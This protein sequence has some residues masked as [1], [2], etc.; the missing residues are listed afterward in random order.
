MTLP[1]ALDAMGGDFAPGEIIAGARRAVD[2]LGLS[3]TLVGVPHLMGDPLGLEVV[4]CS[5]VIAMDDDPASSVR[6]KKDASLVRAA[7]LVRDGRASAM[8][9]AGNTGAT[10][11]SALLRMGRLPGVVRPCI[12]TPIPNPGRTPSV[13]VDAG[14]N[15]ECTAEMLVQ[16][17]Q[18]ASTYV[19]VHYGV[20]APTVGL[21]SIG[22]ESSKGTPLVKETHGLLTSIAGLN[23]VGNVEGRDLIPAPVD[24]IVTDGF[25]GNV[26][27][28]T[29]EGALTF[30]FTTV[31]GVV[32][33]NEE[34]RA[35]GRVLLDYLLPVAGELTPENQGGAML[36]GLNGICVISHGSSN[37]TAVMN[38]LR[39]AAEMDSAGVVD[40]LRTTIRPDQAG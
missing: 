6:K 20:A 10:M 39:V 1:I 19:N 7:E 40:K 28:K 30:I 13:L 29:L 32:E 26:A 5:E 9:S 22:E 2:E 23:F 21:L 25:T 17:A 35:A 3:V 38:A 15:A 24:V 16:F 27:L 12:A 14:A 31:L 4:A 18:M 37:A 11:A 33:T 34:T 8:V 36:L